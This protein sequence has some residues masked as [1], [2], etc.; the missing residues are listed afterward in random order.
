[1]ENPNSGLA[2]AAAEEA[3]EPR[4]SHHAIDRAS[5]RVLDIW[6]G[7]KRKNG[8][9]HAWL[10]R[11]AAEALDQQDTDDQGRY[12]HCGMRWVFEIREH[13]PLLLTVINES[14]NN[15]ALR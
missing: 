5:L 14:N 11:N 1:M 12:I 15:V 3:A 13:P 8:G 4:I 6:K 10:V 9:I 2:E 7:T